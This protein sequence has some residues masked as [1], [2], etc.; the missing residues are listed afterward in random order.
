MANLP[1]NFNP[2][3]VDQGGWIPMRNQSLVPPAL[4]NCLPC[5][6]APVVFFVV[7]DFTISLCG[8]SHEYMWLCLQLLVGSFYVRSSAYQEGRYL[9]KS[10]KQIRIS[11]IMLCLIA[12][13]T[14][15]NIGMHYMLS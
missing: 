10:D 12:G 4:T 9:E 11:T 5:K 8:L 7:V 6:F 3:E 2:L 15:R 1:D 13:I 14:L